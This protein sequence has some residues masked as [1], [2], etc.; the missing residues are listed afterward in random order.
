MHQ[1]VDLH[2]VLQQCVQ[3]AAESAALSVRN[4]PPGLLAW[5]LHH[6][7]HLHHQGQH[8]LI[9]TDETETNKETCLKRHATV[10]TGPMEGRAITQN[11]A[12][13]SQSVGA[14]QHS[15]L[16][17]TR[18]YQQQ[19]AA[20]LSTGPLSV[21][22][23]PFYPSREEL[24]HWRRQHHFMR[25]CRIYSSCQRQ[26]L[27]RKMDLKVRRFPPQLQLSR[28]VCIYHMRK[29]LSLLRQSIATGM[30]GVVHCI[31]SLT[32]RLIY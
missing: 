24:C 5:R 21:I 8:V 15:T 12:T 23:G 4:W 18:C 28:T 17:S 11:S 1:P 13:T 7:T 9:E 10:H 27:Q 20:V 26:H 6:D 14:W 30:Q 19:G 32:A 16:T 3:R 22:T 29:T 2:S 25:G 31:N